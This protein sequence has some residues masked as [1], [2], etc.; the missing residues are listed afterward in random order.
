MDRKADNMT[1]SAMSAAAHTLA[2]AGW[3]VFPCR[4]DKRPLNDHGHLEATA[5]LA[6]VDRWWRRWPNALIGARVPGSSLVIDID[7]RNGGDLA[8]LIELVGPLPPTLTV[9]SG[10]NDGGRHLYFRRPSGLVTT[11]TRLPKGID[12]KINGYCIMPPSI[13]PATGQ[14]YRWE[15][16]EPAILPYRLQELLR[17]TPPPRRTVTIRGDR[18]GAGLVRTVAEAQEHERNSKLSWAAYRAALDGLLDDLE[19]DLIAAAT[20]T[21]LPEAEA[22]RTVASARKGAAR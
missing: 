15:F 10:R 6:Q 21:G 22:L 11:S 16:H 4:R 9:W 13:H 19:E 2:A 17:H 1:A 3:A 12:L 8:K 7:P 14:P 20:S 18:N 5:D